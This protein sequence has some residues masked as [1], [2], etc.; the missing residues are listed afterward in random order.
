M[1]DPDFN[2]AL[3]ILKKSKKKTKGRPKGYKKQNTILLDYRSWIIEVDNC[4]PSY[5]YIVKKKNDTKYHH[6]AY[7]GSLESALKQIY[8]IMLLNNVNRKNDYGANFRDL[9]NLIIETKNEFSQLLDVN[10]V[11]EKRI[12]R[13]ENE[14]V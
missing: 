2:T 6:V 14:T 10:P 11:I 7:C 1:K 9:S 4:F 13:G 8:T 5:N 3:E 12:K